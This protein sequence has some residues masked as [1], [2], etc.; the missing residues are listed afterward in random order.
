MCPKCKKG[1]GRPLEPDEMRCVCD[2]SPALSQGVAELE[3]KH[4]G[5]VGLVGNMLA[6]LKV[7]RNLKTITTSNDET[8]DQFIKNW[9]SDFI[10]YR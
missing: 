7:N 2:S 4:K 9:D 8:F 6:V 5:L 10:K 3:V 1:I